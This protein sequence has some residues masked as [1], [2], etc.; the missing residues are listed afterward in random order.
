MKTYNVLLSKMITVIGASAKLCPNDTLRA[1]FD[2]QTAIISSEIPTQ[3]LCNE[4]TTPFNVW[5]YFATFIDKIILSCMKSSTELDLGLIT[6][7]NKGVGS[8]NDGGG[9]GVGSKNDWG[10]NRVKRRT[11]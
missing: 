4:N 5:K 11:V 9:G 10:K 1:A 8:K 6:G 3:T 2:W 7:S